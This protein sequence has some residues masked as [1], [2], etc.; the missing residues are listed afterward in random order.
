MKNIMLFLLLGATPLGL[1]AQSPTPAREPPA[2]ST[3]AENAAARAE[4]AILQK[5]LAELSKR[6]AEVSMKMGGDGPKVTAMRFLASPNKAMV[7]L[8]LGESD[9]GVRVGGVTPD[10]PAAQA[11]MKSGDIITRVREKE[12]A[13]GNAAQALKQTREALAGLEDGDKVEIGYMRDGKTA[14]ASVT[15]ARREAVNSYRLLADGED[16]DMD[17]ADGNVKVIIKH[18]GNG[19]ADGVDDEAMDG[20]VV[21]TIRERAFGDAGRS[22]VEIHHSL[23]GMPWWGINLAELN[24]DLGRYFGSDQ[25]VLVLSTDGDA[26]TGVKAGDVIQQVAG[27]KVIRPEDALRRLRD[28]PTGSQVAIQVIRDRKPVTLS[29]RVPDNQSLFEMMPPPEPPQPPDAP[30]APLPPKT[31]SAVVPPS[32]PT[33]AR[34]PQPPPAPPVPPAPQVRD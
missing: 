33:P 32:S 27:S 34:A 16:I 15:A 12:I 29:V 10:G 9:Q 19:A 28:Q 3:S 7:G 25:G 13:T 30:K 26:L 11:G 6:M 23:G 21:Q 4:M 24:T 17:G 18:V 1:N 31:P 8:L 14:K 5:Q 2:A 22:R 20:Q